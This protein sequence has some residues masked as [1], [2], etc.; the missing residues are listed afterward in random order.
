MKI[1]YTFFALL[2]TMI[3]FAQSD[4]SK[5]LSKIAEAPSATRIE[6]DIRKLVSFGTRR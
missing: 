2:M 4:V 3:S 6:K 5:I 1:K